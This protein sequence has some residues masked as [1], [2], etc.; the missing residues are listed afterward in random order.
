LGFSRWRDVGYDPSQWRE[1]PDAEAI[2]ETSQAQADLTME[3]R[4]LGI[5]IQA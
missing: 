1:Y 3:T 5:G 2:A 4:Y